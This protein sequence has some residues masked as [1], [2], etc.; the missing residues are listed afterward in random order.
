[1]LAKKVADRAK[2]TAVFV[3]ETINCTEA[4]RKFQLCIFCDLYCILWSSLINCSSYKRRKSTER[5]FLIL[6]TVS[7]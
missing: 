2:T 6:T 7:A 1:M 4:Y 3:L 5:N